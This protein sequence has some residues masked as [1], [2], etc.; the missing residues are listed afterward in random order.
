MF[1]FT[2]TTFITTI[3]NKSYIVKSTK[4]DNTLKALINRVRQNL[5]EEEN[6]IILEYLNILRVIYY[7]KRLKYY[8][9][10]IFSKTISK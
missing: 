3:I 2:L 5:E 10:N 9:P 8:N 7:L 1:T 4:L 6:S